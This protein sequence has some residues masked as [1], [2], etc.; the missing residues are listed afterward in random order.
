MLA[1]GNILSSKLSIEAGGNFVLTSTDSLFHDGGSPASP[2]GPWSG[3]QSATEAK[4]TTGG[5]ATK[6][7][8]TGGSG[9]GLLS[10]G[11]TAIIT[12]VQAAL[13]AASE[14]NIVAANNVVIVAQSLN[15]N[16]ILQAGISDYKAT[17]DTSYASKITSAET[18]RTQYLNGQYGSAYA[19]AAAAGITPDDGFTFFKL[20]GPTI[21]V[22]ASGLEYSTS[23][24]PNNNLPIYYNAQANRLEATPTRVQGG[25][26]S[27]TGRILNTNPTAQIRVMDGY[28]QITIKNDLD[29]PLYINRLDTGNPGATDNGIEGK[30][31]IT[32]SGNKNGAGAPLVTEYTRLG[33]D[34]SKKE[35]YFVTPG[36]TP[37][38]LFNGDDPSGSGRTATYQPKSSEYRFYWTTGQ[39]STKK[40]YT[41]YGTSAWLNIDAFAADPDD[42][43]EGPTVEYATPRALA[44]GNYLSL[45]SAYEPGEPD[46]T[47]E[48]ERIQ[49][50][51]PQTE[52]IK[53]WETST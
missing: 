30:L 6:G 20:T 11:A 25:F 26:M 40:T 10:S 24:D 17:I 8:V 33:S 46:Y 21:K 35:Y 39:D 7:S 51:T 28:G 5:V 3:V 44:K 42:I 22:D 18:A 16:G 2:T 34:I 45:D 23:T 29:I 14:S 31:I 27:L 38:L 13:N 49:Q 37:T 48:F 15:L 41:T 19:T 1:R 36:K 47:Y 9:T 32:D 4:G 52:V 12:A 50:G 53:R 43:T